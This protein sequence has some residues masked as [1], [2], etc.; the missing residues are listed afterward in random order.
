MYRH[1]LV[2]IWLIVILNIYVIDWVGW[3]MEFEGSVGRC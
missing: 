3:M 1:L 2:I